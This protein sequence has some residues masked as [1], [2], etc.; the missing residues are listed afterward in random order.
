M[1]RIQVGRLTG[2]DP[3]TPPSHPPYGIGTPTSFPPASAEASS[4]C[5]KE[6]SGR[7]GGK[8]GFD[9]SALSFPHII[10]Q[11]LESR[12]T[13]QSESAVRKYEELN[14]KLANDPRLVHALR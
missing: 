12:L 14:E 3:L 4:F 2:H 1:F 11:I 13:Q 6:T 5:L 7:R 10:S 9:A 8:G